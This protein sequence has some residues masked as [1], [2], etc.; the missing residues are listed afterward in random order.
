LDNTFQAEL[1]TIRDHLRFAVSR[2]GEAGLV[3]GHGTTTALDDA[4]FLIL[5]TLNLPHETLEPWL[6]ARLTRAERGKV[7]AMIE[8]R[9]VTRKPTSYLTKSAYIGPYRF[10]VDERVIVPR[11]FIGELLCT[12]DG[13]PFGL[14]QTP[15]RILD[16]CT[17]SGCLA[18]VAAHLFPDATVVAADISA[19]ALAVAARNVADHKLE[20]RVELVGSDLFATITAPAFDLIL[21]N[22]P[23]VTATAVAAFPAEYTAEPQLAH[24]GGDDG[25]DL[26]RRVLDEA[27]RHLRPHGT[28]VMEIGQGRPILE[29]DYPQV[30]FLWLETAMSQGEVFALDARALH[31]TRNAGTKG[32]KPRTGAVSK[33]SPRQ[34]KTSETPG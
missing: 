17:G 7:L 20:H 11:S 25:M 6:D 1:I 14:M 12:Q 22:P 33:K 2:F 10:V 4:A 5:E 19:G 31:G 3:Y 13:L 30:P 28:L 27:G 9:V 32:T 15:A 24:L 26:V 21:C 18:I 23:Y 8:T 16:L 29:R 34:T